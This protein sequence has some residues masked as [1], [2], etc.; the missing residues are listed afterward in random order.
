MDP[1]VASRHAAASARR[2][3]ACQ[4]DSVF[5]Q[6]TAPAGLLAARRIASDVW[7][8]LVVHGGSLLFGF[9]DRS[10]DAGTEA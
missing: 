5:D 10:E 6:E 9:E 4:D 3:R 7:G 8:R 1:G 2:S